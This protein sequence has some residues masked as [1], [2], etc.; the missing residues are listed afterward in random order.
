M[1]PLNSLMK[2]SFANPRFV[3]IPSLLA[4]KPDPSGRNSWTK[5]SAILWYQST[6][7]VTLDGPRWHSAALEGG[8]TQRVPSHRVGPGNVFDSEL[9]GEP[10][11]VPG[12]RHDH[13][14]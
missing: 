13:A 2:G 8:P 9:G 10:I 6:Q 5:V 1:I 4:I 11:L 12:S 7:C 14:L 3:R